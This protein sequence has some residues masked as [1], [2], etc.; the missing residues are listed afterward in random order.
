MEHDSSYLLLRSKTLG[1]NST[2]APL[3]LQ[4]TLALK[5]YGVSL[6]SYAGYQAKLHHFPHSPYTEHHK[7]FNKLFASE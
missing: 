3:P 1:K 5:K 6:S 4:S 2:I 7:P